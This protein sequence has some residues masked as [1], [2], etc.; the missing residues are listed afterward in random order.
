ML[1]VERWN[2][3]GRS[4]DGSFESFSKLKDAL[5]RVQDAMKEEWSGLLLTSRIVG[6]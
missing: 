2:N 5:E 4:R 6:T 3:E 1:E